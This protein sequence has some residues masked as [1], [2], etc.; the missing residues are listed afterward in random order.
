MAS[1]ASRLIFPALLACLLCLDSRAEAQDEIPEIDVVDLVMFDDPKFKFPEP[2]FEIPTDPI[3]V[4]M[5][6]LQRAED[7]ELQRVTLDTLSIAKRLGMEG[8]DAFKPTLIELL[9]REELDLS[10]RRSAVSVMIHLDAREEASLLAKQAEQYGE[11]IAEIVESALASWQSGELQDRWLQRVQEGQ[12]GRRS[13]I[14]GAEGLGALKAVEAAKPLTQLVEN[15]GAAMGIRL[16]AARALGRIPFE[17]QLSLADR[18]VSSAK[19]DVLRGVMAVAVLDDRDDASAVDSLKPLVANR[20]S[21][22]QAEALRAL[23]EVDPLLPLEFVE[24]E[25]QNGD[26][27][28]RRPLARSMVRSH[29]AKWV[30]TLAS[31]LNDVNPSLRREVAASMVYL[32]NEHGLRDEVVAEASRVIA[33][34]EWRGCEQATI[35]L[36]NLEIKEIGDRLVQLMDHPR[37]EVQVTAAWGLRRFALEEHLPAMLRRGKQ[38]YAGFRNGELNL[39]TPGAEQLITQLFMAFGQM[40]YS[41]SEGLIRDYLPKDFSLGDDA[42]TA[43]AWAIGFLHEGKATPDVTAILLGRLNDVTSTFAEISPV[44]AMAAISLARMKSEAAVPDLRQYMFGDGSHT[45]QACGWAIEQLTGEP[46]P[47]VR[48][49][50]LTKH[51]KWFLAPLQDGDDA[52]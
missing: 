2:R 38:V 21:A 43:A 25:I 12:S 33:R 46:K 29:D 45:D 6:A 40:R 9:S 39:N 13:L 28:V 1:Y 14:R 11:P 48:L 22:V 17:D 41:E 8:L 35:V 7:T 52:E 36:V 44:R 20:S 34:N 47:P 18:L 42:R 26:V 5:S 23:Y 31:L 37:G 3:R 27:N 16:A 19:T 10:V 50:P 49:G 32:A 30:E 24:A 4:W 51:N 15:D